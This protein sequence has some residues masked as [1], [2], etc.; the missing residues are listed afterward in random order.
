MVVLDLMLP[1]LSGLDVLKLV[2]LESDLPVIILSARVS[3]EER[4]DGPQAGRRRLHRQALLAARGGR[5]HPGGAAPGGGDGPARRRIVAGD[6]VIDGERRRG[7][8][9]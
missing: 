6:L 4:I 2:R 9:G 8:R 3:E 1:R 7:H 5:A